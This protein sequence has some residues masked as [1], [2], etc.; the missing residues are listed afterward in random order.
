MR[1]GIEEPLE[2]ELVAKRVD[3]GDRHRVR[4]DGARARTASRSDGDAVLLRPVDEV[5]DDEEVSDEVHL[6]DDRKLVVR[7]LPDFV[8]DYR[9]SFFQTL[10][11]DPGDVVVF[12]RELLGYFVDR[13]NRARLRDREV[14]HL[15]D[16][17]RVRQHLRIFR[18]QLRHLVGVLEIE[19]VAVE[20]HAVRLVSRPLRSDAEEYVLRDVIFALAVVRVVRHDHRDAEASRHRDQH[21][22]DLLLFFDS[23][24]LQ[25]DEIVAVA[26][27]VAISP[28]ERLGFRRFS[29][30]EEGRELARETGR[31]ADEPARVLLDE[32][33]V[34]T[35]FIV[36]SFRERLRGQHHEVA[37]AF[38]VLRD[39]DEV[40]V[41]RGV[42][43][44]AAFRALSRR[45]VKLAADERV[46]SLILAFAVK[47]ERSEHIAVVGNRDGFLAHGLCVGDHFL[48]G[49]GAVE[50]RIVGVNVEM[51][52]ILHGWMI[53]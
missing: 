45:D 18:E 1:S 34:D 40:I 17:H 4:D 32:F 5:P 23:V 46:Y 48:E 35:G 6:D 15:G 36:H 49:R 8:G 41:F 25:L 42:L 2:E 10:V 38:L 19:L 3:I 20:S 14:A 24:I 43:A 16:A 22:G 30:E 13:Q 53:A 33:L 7:A 51:D 52:E 12:V 44:R 21:R 37:I 50:K 28:R 29:V 47:A 27:V 31:K 9:I 26:E 39:Q 11:D